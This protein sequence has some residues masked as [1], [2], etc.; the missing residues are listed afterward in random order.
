MSGMFTPAT[1][2]VMWQQYAE[3]YRAVAHQNASAARVALRHERMLR[4]Q[5]LITDCKQIV[6]GLM[7]AVFELTEPFHGAISWAQFGAVMGFVTLGVL[8]LVLDILDNRDRQ[9]WLAA[10]KSPR[11]DPN[12][13]VTTPD[14]STD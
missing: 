2:A 8:S 1:R 11:D 10:R 7:L 6:L 12:F 14:Q 13:P 3:S 9:R 5:R 4:K